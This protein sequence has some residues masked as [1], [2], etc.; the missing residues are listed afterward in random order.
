MV[1]LTLSAVPAL[2]VLGASDGFSRGA[3]PRRAAR[4]RGGVALV[5]PPT[6]VAMSPFEI[7]AED[8][9]DAPALATKSLVELPVMFASDEMG[10]EFD[11]ARWERHRSTTR[12]PRLIA[13]TFSGETTKRILP[14]LSVLFVLTT[15]VY[16]YNALASG[17]AY[18][19]DARR[20]GDLAA[21]DVLLP[22]LQLPIEPFELS[23]PVLGERERS[24]RKL[25][26]PPL[27]SVRERE[28]GRSDRARPRERAR[29]LRAAVSPFSHGSRRCVAVVARARAQACCSCSARTSRT[30]GSTA[31]AS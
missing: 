15:V 4:P 13:G 31:A 9:R 16:L 11:F 24:G 18:S 8:A 7:R 5:R 3:A 23:S 19:Y 25:S 21:F 2:L 10:S 1:R 14:P 26:P 28:S 6:V 29:A 12:Y 30:T 22:E 27:P 17:D 20:L